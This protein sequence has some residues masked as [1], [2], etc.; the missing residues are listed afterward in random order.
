MEKSK[1]DCSEFVVISQSSTLSFF[2]GT[3]YHEKEGNDFISSQACTKYLNLQVIFEAD[4]LGK[5]RAKYF[6]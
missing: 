1:H 6:D 4:V 5:Y 2:K 3:T